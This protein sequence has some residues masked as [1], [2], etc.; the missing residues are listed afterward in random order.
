MQEFS[1][2]SENCFKII[3]SIIIPILST[4]MSPLSSPAF[5]QQDLAS[6]GLKI[7]DKLKLNDKITFNTFSLLTGISL[8]LLITPSLASNDWSTVT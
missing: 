4:L 5:V 8:L 1:H 3:H 6:S 7:H 2:S